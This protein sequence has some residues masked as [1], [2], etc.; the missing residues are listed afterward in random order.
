MTRHL[1]VIGKRS[2]GTI[3]VAVLSPKKK[4]FI[5]LAVVFT[6]RIDYYHKRLFLYLALK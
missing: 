6:L 3:A 5:G 1:S 4:K 2:V